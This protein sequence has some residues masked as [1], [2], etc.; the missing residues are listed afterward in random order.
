MLCSPKSVVPT[1]IR[2]RISFEDSGRFRFGLALPSHVGMGNARQSYL[3]PVCKK[4]KKKN[5]FAARPGL[6]RQGPSGLWEKRPGP[7]APRGPRCRDLDPA[8]PRRSGVPAEC[9]RLRAD[10]AVSRERGGKFSPQGKSIVDTPSQGQGT[11]LQPSPPASL[12]AVWAVA[13]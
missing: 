12:Q 3:E 6:A 8:D 11:L 10:L 13:F 4:R 5:L 7:N 9:G 2:P 1:R